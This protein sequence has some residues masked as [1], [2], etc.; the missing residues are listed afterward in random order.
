[1]GNNREFNRSMNDELQKKL[2]KEPLYEKLLLYIKDSGDVFSAIRNE[3]V[4]F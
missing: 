2:K 4:D 1:M 3:R